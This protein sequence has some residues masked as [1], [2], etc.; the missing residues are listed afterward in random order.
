MV[1]LCIC[2][3]FLLCM[4]ILI[5]TDGKSNEIERTHFP[6]DKC[7]YIYKLQ[8]KTT[9]YETRFYVRIVIFTFAFRNCDSNTY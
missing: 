7:Q 4:V 3:C 8:L 2:L 9:L 1:G 6:V 5:H